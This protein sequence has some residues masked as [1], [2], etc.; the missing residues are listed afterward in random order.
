MTYKP[1]A[2]EGERGNRIYSNDKQQGDL[3]GYDK[4]PSNNV[5]STKRSKSTPNGIVTLF[6]SEL[7]IKAIKGML[8]IPLITFDGPMS[9]HQ[10]CLS[11]KSLA[12]PIR[13]TR[14]KRFLGSMYSEIEKMLFARENNER[15][16]AILQAVL[17]ESS[18]QDNGNHA[19]RCNL[20]EISRPVVNL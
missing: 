18:A 20:I 17:L 16:T 2:H 11:M 1:I 8:E 9:N 19:N 5:Y 13:I 3:H 12:V 14:V 7:P 4:S 6:L 10:R 15:Q